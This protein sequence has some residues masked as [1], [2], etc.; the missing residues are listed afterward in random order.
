MPDE[1]KPEV[2]PT[3]E[4]Y[5]S[6]IQ[7]F[8]GKVTDQ[9]N[10]EVIKTLNVKNYGVAYTQP[11]WQKTDRERES[12]ITNRPTAEVTGSPYKVPSKKIPLPEPVAQ[13][14]PI[15]SISQIPENTIAEPELPT[16]KLNMPFS[17]PIVLT[18]TGYDADNVPIFVPQKKGQSIF[19]E[20]Q[21]W[22]LQMAAVSAW[23]TNNDYANA[24]ASAR[25]S[26]ISRQSQ[27]AE[28]EKY[29]EAVK[30]NYEPS[31]EE[32][33]K[34]MAV[35]NVENFIKALGRNTMSAV[36]TVFGSPFWLLERGIGT[37]TLEVSKNIAD[38][39]IPKDITLEESWN[40]SRLAFDVFGKKQNIMAE[41]IRRYRED[42]N[43]DPSI[44]GKD[45]ENPWSELIVGVLFDPLNEVDRINKANKALKTVKNAQHLAL[46]ETDELA[47]GLSKVDDVLRG[48]DNVVPVATDDIVK[49]VD[50]TSPFDIQIQ[51]AR[52]NIDITDVEFRK[53]REATDVAKENVKAL[54][55]AG[56]SADEI[57][58]AE[59]EAK[60]LGKIAQEAKKKNYRW[61]KNLSEIE[62]SAK[63]ERVKAGVIGG[64]GVKSSIQPPKSNAIKEAF[65]NLVAAT[66]KRVEKA[67]LDLGELARNYKDTTMKKVA[68][69]GDD[70]R[71][72]MTLIFTAHSDI[73]DYGEILKSMIT[74]AS[75]D[76]SD[77]AKQTAMAIIHRSPM[78]KVILSEAGMN[79]SIVLR[80]MVKTNKGMNI[81]KISKIIENAKNSADP[82]LYLAENLDAKAYTATKSMFPDMFDRVNAVEQIE[83]L[84]KEGKPIPEYL[85]KFMV[86][87]Q[88]EQI[89]DV[90]KRTVKAHDLFQNKILFGKA[91]LADINKYMSGAFIAANPPTWFR[92]AANN[93]TTIFVDGGNPFLVGEKLDGILSKWGSPSQAEVGLGGTAATVPGTEAQNKL[94][95]WLGSFNTKVEK[96]QAKQIV[97]KTLK[98]AIDDQFKVIFRDIQGG[99]RNAGFSEEEITRLNRLIYDT[100]D[101]DKG[102]ETLFNIAE[103]RTISDFVDTESIKG[104]AEANMDDDITAAIRSSATKEQAKQNVMDVFADAKRMGDDAGVQEGVIDPNSK[105]W[106][107]V[108]DLYDIPADFVDGKEIDYIGRKTIATQTAFEKAS[109]VISGWRNTIREEAQ[110]I[111]YGLDVAKRQELDNKVN[112]ASRI[113]DSAEAEFAKIRR[114]ASEWR[115]REGAELLRRAKEAEKTDR[116][117]AGAL[118]NEF[119]QMREEMWTKAGQD[120]IAVYQ[121]A[122]QDA[123][124]ALGGTKIPKPNI[125]KFE[126]SINTVSMWNDVDADTFNL[127]GKAVSKTTGEAILNP[128]GDALLTIQDAFKNA[129]PQLQ[130]VMQKI[131]NNIDDKFDNILPSEITPEKLQSLRD[132]AVTARERLAVAKAKAFEV[133]NAAR[134]FTLLDYRK[135][136]TADLVAAYLFPYQFWYSRSYTN[137]L[138]RVVDKPGMV[139]NYMR[140]RN[141]LEKINADMPEWYRY[142]INLGHIVG[143]PDDNPLYF[144]LEQMIN[145]LN[146]LLGMD[147][148]DSRRRKDLFPSVIDAIG[149]YGPSTHPLYSY[150]I[151]ATYA[152]SGDK[153]SAEAWAGRFVPQT[154]LIKDATSALGLTGKMTGGGITPGGV[155]IDPIIIAMGGLDPYEKKRVSR[156]LAELVQRGEIT[157]EEA[158]EASYKHSGDAWNK[159]WQ[160][161]QNDPEVE[162]YQR[163][164]VLSTFGGIFGTGL[165]GR[166]K[167]DVLND[168]FFEEYSLLRGI[169]N[170]LSPSEYKQKLVSLFERYPF[171]EYLVLSR[172]N[173]KY[174]DQAWAY[175]VLDRIQ[176]GQVGQIAKN[177][178]LDYKVLDKFYED[179]GRIDKW[180]EADYQK[181]MAGI[182]DISVVLEIPDAAT[183]HDWDVA[184]IRNMQ[185]NEYL[186]EKYGEDITDRINM[187]YDID[188]T[189]SAKRDEYLNDNPDVRE[190][191]AEKDEATLADP[192]L[193]KYYGG[194]DKLET[195]LQYQKRGQAVKLFGEDIFQLVAYYNKAKTLG[196]DIRAIQDDYP[197]ISKYMQWAGE[198][199]KIID[200]TIDE[201]GAINLPQ[202]ARNVVNPNA[203]L[204]SIGQQE[205]AKYLRENNPNADEESF[206]APYM[207]PRSESDYTGQFSIGKYIDE[208]AEKRWIGVTDRVSEFEAAKAINPQ[209]ARSLW[210]NDP[211]ISM[212]YTFVR[213]IQSQSA[214]AEKGVFPQDNIKEQIMQSLDPALYRLVLDKVNGMEIPASAEKRIKRIATQLGITY[215]EL[216]MYM[217]E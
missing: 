169:Q 186:K 209:L 217:L 35:T 42:P 127:T 83:K 171:G 190:A 126:D 48:A 170:N 101:V 111:G 68:I 164:G 160:Y 151:A 179:K 184:R 125:K 199:N 26:I 181:F 2:N 21:A 143:L 195:Y 139:A 124:S 16:V 128:D 80:N 119:K 5:Q 216:M 87:G 155:E 50:T 19:E 38:S 175:S 205:L 86:N 149:K 176:P 1:K 65:N 191:I 129:D 67:E 196:Y 162:W 138:K 31:E 107:E 204:N 36:T 144:Q 122:I 206:L 6:V 59:E 52:K 84:T 7:Q 117:L 156:K 173:D 185:L 70:V 43:A 130:A 79:T 167:E 17:D 131:L 152:I 188:A 98:S 157:Q 168:K 4:L 120:Q 53:A 85:N 81:G 91:G 182:R 210:E 92:N 194:I 44:I 165:R 29:G 96:Y 112:S 90:I 123:Q 136:S 63:T 118:Y 100:G 60:R 58:M 177:V 109:E 61:N 141:T 99:L 95:K 197:Q 57:A 46:S 64:S 133:A 135:K 172:K 15:T 154:K 208:E 88:P 14:Q 78:R 23:R 200:K 69:I 12:I 89:P 102:I 193:N 148:Q 55:S 24:K 30:T 40:A 158:A 8:G 28:A 33:D 11:L 159:A 10:R 198:Q 39:G 214:Q 74:I 72:T 27:Q 56:A 37:A 97:A 192:M 116:E 146:G 66:T 121:K 93:A 94:F 187:L 150:M 77:I 203:I 20:F 113:L 183:Q 18:A 45:L 161:A 174:R 22:Q 54:K 180:D 51:D 132:F 75:K 103:N 134:E 9:I 140:Y 76:A 153:D 189:D 108:E 211:T 166:T 13:E 82:L 114:R 212:Y 145:P 106:S 32:I 104:L 163:R 62:Q 213:G 110:K 178:G 49:T 215:N 202:I 47:K 207:T 137:W 34:Q 25:A 3:E 142:Q 71:D 73:D 115:Q 201:W 105:Y 41:Y 147:F